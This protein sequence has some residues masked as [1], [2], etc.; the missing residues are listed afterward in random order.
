[1]EAVTQICDAHL[2]DNFKLGTNF[3]DASIF[4]I[5][6]EVAPTFNDTM[7]FCKWR[8]ENN[9]CTAFF[10][11]ILTEE[12]ICYTFNALNSRDIYT[13]EYVNFFFRLL[14]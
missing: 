10:N 12:G 3:T 1:M 13:D 6:Q 11:P 14:K 5:I 7:F 8:N 4:D 2:V 9:F